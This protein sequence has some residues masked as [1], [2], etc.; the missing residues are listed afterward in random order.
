M[1]ARRRDIRQYAA[2][3]C[4]SMPW[5]RV[6]AQRGDTRQHAAGNVTACRGDFKIELPHLRYFENRFDQIAFNRNV[7]GTANSTF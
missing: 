3:T 6:T 7:K 5:G 4:D 2:G 1:T